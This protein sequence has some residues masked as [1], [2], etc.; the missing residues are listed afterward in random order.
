VTTTL[1]DQFFGPI[2]GAI[3]LRHGIMDSARLL[4]L[5]M[6]RWLPVVT[7]APFLGGRN[8][9]APIK[10]G[11]GI[12]FSLWM[13]PWLSQMA[14][15]PLEFTALFW[16]AMLL[17]EMF[18]GLVLG[19]GVSLIFW[20]A[21]MGGRFID[22]VRGG[23]TANLFIPQVQIQSSILGS[24]YFQFFIALFVVVGGHRWFLS[25]VIDSYLVVTPFELGL[26]L[27]AVANAFIERTAL[28]FTIAVKLIAPALAVVILLDLVLG[29]A[30]RMAPQLNVFFFSLPL[31]S[32]LSFL[33]I[34]LSLYYVFA[35]SLD[36]FGDQDQ[37]LRGTTQQMRS[38]S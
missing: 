14:P 32:A 17:R 27:D 21:E 36:F 16:W 19:L 35:L 33:A 3:G 22:N 38:G 4:M 6:A 28:M 29:I 25:G 26:Q 1:L 9:V 24:F 34:G 13:L 10:F 8:V 15:A 37:W 20:S 18:I 12:M 5:A 11:L 2:G 30:N 7:L 23:T 31:K